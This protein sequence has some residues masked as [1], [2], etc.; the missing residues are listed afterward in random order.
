VCG[1]ITATGVL[2]TSVRRVADAEK[3]I[4]PARKVATSESVPL[5]DE[6]YVDTASGRAI[7]R[8]GTDKIIDLVP[9]PRGKADKDDMIAFTLAMSPLYTR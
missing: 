6:G 8:V 4:A 2:Y 5:G 9:L 7:I 3:V 1:W